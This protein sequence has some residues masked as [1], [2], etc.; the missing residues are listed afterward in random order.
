[1]IAYKLTDKKGQTKNKTQ[2]GENVTHSATGNNPK[3][4]SNGWIH[5]YADPLIAVFMNPVHAN[6]VNP[7]LWKCETAGEHKHEP[8]KSGCKILTTLQQIDLP[9]VT[10]TQRIAFGI[11]CAKQVYNNAEWNKWADNWLTGLNR[12]KEAAYAITFDAYAYAAAAEAI[13]AATA[14]T[15]NLVAIHA[16]FA[17]VHAS[18]VT[19]SVPIDFIA[20][21]KQALNY[22]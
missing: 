5:F 6:F 15:A 1:M 20:L 13:E 17:A 19:S 7:I 21:A 10:T 9:V 14:Y 4:C 3:L 18:Q 16:A 8:L 12:S 22:N 2:W 11:L